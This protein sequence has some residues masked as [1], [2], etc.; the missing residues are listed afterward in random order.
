MVNEIWKKIRIMSMMF[1]LLFTCLSCMYSLNIKTFAESYGPELLITELVPYSKT[2]DDA[3]EFIELYNNSG[4]KIDLNNYRLPKQKI[5][6]TFSKVIQPKGVLVICTNSATTLEKFNAFYGISLTQE[7][8]ATLPAT[9]Q[10]LSNNSSDDIILA[11]DNGTVVAEAQYGSSNVE[12]R[13]SIT[14]RYSTTGYEMNLLGEKQNPTPGNVTAD[15]IPPSGTRVTGISLDRKSLNM[16]TYQTTTLHAVVYPNTAANKA[17]VWY[18]SNTNV[19]NVNEYSIVT[20]KTQGSAVITARTV[21]NSL[22]AACTVTVIA[23]SSYVPV[24]NVSLNKTDISM[25]AQKVMIL[26]AQIYQDNATNKNVIWSSSN[27]AI[28]SVDENG[29]VCAKGKGS[30]YIT[31]KTS[32]GGYTATCRISVTD[33]SDDDISDSGI[34]LNRL[35]I[36]VETGKTEKLEAKVL[37]RYALDKTVLWESSDEN[38]ASVTSDGAVSGLK[39]G[40]AVITVTTKNENYSDRCL[41]VVIGDK[42]H[43][44]DKINRND[45]G[46]GHLK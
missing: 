25:E 39:E 23:S 4:S 20:A 34:S 38:V 31:V 45:R 35:F 32:D 9:G 7:K 22:T 3:Y 30:C 24:N 12:L 40:F 13:K 21:D 37:P 46:K 2:N 27:S 29:I 16:E 14:Y 19:A 10:L 36:F 33:A 5:D 26:E 17:V 1:A 11:K 8:Y 44:H 28:A 15:Q 43:G 18:S 6:I 41:V 42:I